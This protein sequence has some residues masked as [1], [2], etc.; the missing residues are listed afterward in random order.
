MDINQ[1][2]SRL[3]VQSL[4]ADFNHQQGANYTSSDDYVKEN[5]SNYHFDNF[6]SESEGEWFHVLGRYV[7]NFAY[8]VPKIVEDSLRT[9]WDEFSRSG[10]RN[11][12]N[13]GQSPMTQQEH[14]DR[15]RHGTANMGQ[16]QMV[17]EDFL[18]QFP[19]IKAMVDYWEL[20]NPSYRGHVQMPG[21]TF[22]PHLDKLWHRC[23]ADPGRI[24]RIVINLADWEVG[25]YATYGNVVHSQWRAG[26]VHIFDHHNV[27]HSTINISSSSRPNITLTGL[28]TA[29][30]D[31]KLAMATADSR[32]SV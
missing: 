27:P 22:A 10:K 32:Y 18:N 2:T 1:Y 21:Q 13:G 3:R 6:K 20:E 8:A 5:F 25:Q 4:P 12:P 17:M 19:E 16:T 29:G 23:P 14:N 30:T 9:E 11:F 15:V 7:G 28:R 24:V 31:R 26:D